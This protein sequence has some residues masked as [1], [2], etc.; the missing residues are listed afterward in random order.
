MFFLFVVGLG[1][2]IGTDVRAGH[3]RSVLG[4]PR[5]FKNFIVFS[6]FAMLCWLKGLTLWL[7]FSEKSYKP[8]GPSGP[9]G[10]AGRVFT[11]LLLDQIGRRFFISRT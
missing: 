10:T 9:L 3:L 2:R 6:W 8:K 11:P 5:D 4:L 1:G 7:K